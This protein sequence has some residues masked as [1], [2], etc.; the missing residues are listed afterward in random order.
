MLFEFG[1]L[2]GAQGTV[3]VRFRH[4]FD[5]V[6]AGSRI[7]RHYLINNRK[8]GW[9]QSVMPLGDLASSDYNVE[10]AIF[11]GGPLSLFGRIFPNPFDYVGA[12]SDGQRRRSG[13]YADGERQR[14]PFGLDGQVVRD[15]PPHQLFE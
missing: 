6:R 7:C 15:I 10:D 13:V 1:S 3:A 4:L 2:D 5:V 9:P 8:R 14:F 11:V 12:A